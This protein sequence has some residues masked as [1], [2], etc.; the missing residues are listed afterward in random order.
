M[1]LLKLNPIYVYIQYY[2]FN[3]LVYINKNSLFSID[4]CT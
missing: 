4:P 1:V 3:K 2:F